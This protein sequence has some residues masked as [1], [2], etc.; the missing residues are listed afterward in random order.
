MLVIS[1]VSDLESKSDDELLALRED[2]NRVYG[3]AYRPSYLEAVVYAI[4]AVDK[5]LERRAN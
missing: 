4:R 1:A 3:V 2:L 5:E